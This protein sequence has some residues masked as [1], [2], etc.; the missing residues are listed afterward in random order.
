[1]KGVNMILELNLKF[2]VDCFTCCFFN[3]ADCGIDADKIF[4]PNG[5]VD[6]ELRYSCFESFTN[7]IDNEFLDHIKCARAMF[8]KR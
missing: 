4:F 2:P 5:C 6:Y 3:G 8:A 1:M 7:F